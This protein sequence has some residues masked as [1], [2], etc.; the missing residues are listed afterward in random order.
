MSERIVE[1]GRK[2]LGIAYVKQGR[3]EIALDCGGF[4]IQVFRDLGYQINDAF[5]YPSKPDGSF[6]KL[7]EAHCDEITPK[8]NFQIGDVL[9]FDL[10]IKG[11]VSHIAILTQIEPYLKIIH[12][13]N[14]G[15]GIVTEHR[16]MHGTNLHRH[17]I[18]TYRIK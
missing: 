10:Q 15:K 1:A 12:S 5:G 14:A 2:Y 4:V 3:G 7:L 17:W 18:K 6:E 8:E 9:A 11:L 16:L 13:S